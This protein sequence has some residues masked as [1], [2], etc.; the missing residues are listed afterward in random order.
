MWRTCDSELRS[1]HERQ[2]D[3]DTDDVE[4]HEVNECSQLLLTTTTKDAVTY[5]L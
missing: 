2:A 4:T 5:P 1:Q 3:G